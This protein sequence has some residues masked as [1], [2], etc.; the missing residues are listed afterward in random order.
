MTAI[1]MTN[2]SLSSTD[3]LNGHV[4][5]ATLHDTNGIV[6]NL[7]QF[8][9]STELWKY[10]TTTGLPGSGQEGPSP[11]GKTWNGALALTKDIPANTSQTFT[12]FLAWHFPHRYVNW[13]QKGFG[14][15]DTTTQFYIGNQYATFWPNISEVLEYT[16]TNLTTL[17]AQT[18]MFR[19]AMFN[20]T[21]PWQLID[22]AAARMMVLRS[23]TCM[24]QADGNFYAFEGCSAQSG[25]CP[26]NCTHVWNYE[27]A[28]SRL[29]PDLERTMRETDL[30][31]QIS[32]NSIIPSRTTVPLEL[33]RQWTFWPNYT[34]INQAST[35]I[36]VDGEIGTVNKTYREVLQGAP[37]KWFD[38]QWPQVKKIMDRWMTTL[39]DGTGV[40]RGP[41][42]NT[43]DC[44][45][46]GV[47]TFIGTQYLCALRAAEEMAK[48][49][50]DT[51]SATSYHNR[52]TSGSTQLDKLCFTNGKW[53]TQVVD[54]AHDTN[55]M[56]DGTFVD[57]LGGWWWARSLG[58]GD[59]LPIEH[60]RSSLQN[61]FQ[62][63]HVTAFNPALQY[64][65]KFF[66]QRDA[67]MFIIRWPDGTVPRNGL[68]YSSEGA[69]TGLEYPF[70]GQC[71]YAGLND[72]ALQVLT[73]AREKY[74]GTR[75]S[76]W[77]EVECGDHYSRQMGGFLLFEIASG[78]V[79]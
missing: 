37:K 78:Q 35:A 33:R 31:Q 9:A 7:S 47:N 20:S 69:W 49:Q 26:L 36:C 57:A 53:Y 3:A 5:L 16:Q 22:S 4:A 55:V 73:E 44:A 43:Y 60:V 72:I 74:D 24:W 12:F 39:D 34:D 62:Q 6:T 32:P 61:T 27:M 17:T 45:V 56:S 38:Q 65:R 67:G 75:R 19:D 70:A 23:P 2:A 42:P 79:E 59:I 14:I 28:L 76:P 15:Q 77:N 11:S 41:Q 54:S 71:L 18:R 30:Q 52:F 29:Y 1:D 21:L 10:F 13:S 48:L 8:D 40:I 51:A 25:C 68:L 64:P 46:Y 58:L 50:G 66:D 63:N